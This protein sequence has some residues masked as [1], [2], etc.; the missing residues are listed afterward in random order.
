[1]LLISPQA[2]EDL[3]NIWSYIA[4]DSPVNADRFLSYLYEQAQHLLELPQSGRLRAE[5]AP[6]V[7]SFPVAKYLLFYREQ[8]SNIELIRVLHA[9]RDI[10]TLF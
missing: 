4:S 1:M 8:G 3:L 9:A 10:D 6:N 2:E 5:L 7:R